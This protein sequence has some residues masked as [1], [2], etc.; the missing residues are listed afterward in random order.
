MEN[1]YESGFAFILEGATELTFYD[2]LLHFLLRSTKNV[3]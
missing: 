2:S 1:A 3:H